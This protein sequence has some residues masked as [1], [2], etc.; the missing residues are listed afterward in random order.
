MFKTIKAHKWKAIISTLILL[1]PMAVGFLLWN[2]LPN[3]MTIHWGADGIADGMGSKIFAVAGLPLILL[4]LHWVCILVTCAD[5]GNKNQTRKATGL[6][7]W[8]LPLCS[9]LIHGALFSAALGH[10]LS[11]T[12]EPALLGVL[13]LI[14]GNYM[15]KIK[16]N[17]TLGIKVTWTVRDEA[18]WN[19]THRFAGKIW[20]IGGL[21]L[22][23]SMFLPEKIFFTIMLIVILV[24][25]AAPFLYSYLFYKKQVKEGSYTGYPSPQFKSQKKIT[26]ASI[27]FVILLLAAVG[28]LMFTGRIQYQ[29]GDKTLS[30]DASYWSDL[31]VSYEEFD[32]IEYRDTIGSGMRTNGFASPRLAIGTFQNDEFG[33]YTR[34][35]YTQT[36][37]YIVLHSGERVLVLNSKTEADTQALYKQL[38]LKI[39]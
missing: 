20:M 16:R 29:V 3:N 35:T 37:A 32:R 38:Q 34:Y 12:F 36:D 30:I 1:V 11:L 5:P 39:K 9:L 6:I 14:F 7:F 17:R 24:I 26:L 8:I 31:A 27:I 33:S 19:A 25:A 23:L 2:K 4:A 13:F 10:D 22:L 15:P 18:N 21:V 28:V